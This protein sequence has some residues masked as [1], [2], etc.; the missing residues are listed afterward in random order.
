MRIVIDVRGTGY[1]GFEIADELRRTYD[2]HVKRMSRSERTVAVVAESVATAS[3][4]AV[5]PREACLGAAEI[6]ATED[7][8]GRISCESIA[9]YPPGIPALLPGERISTATA[10]HLRELADAG[11]R[12]HA[13]S[14]PG[15]RT[16]N[17]LK[18]G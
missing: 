5:T 14:D 2:T 11:A 16:I 4:M 12:L 3:V 13:A 1:R 18:E 7:A 8:T 15:F 17:V 9:P 10:E 6:V